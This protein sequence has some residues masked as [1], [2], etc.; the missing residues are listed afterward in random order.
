MVDWG[1][2]WWWFLGTFLDAV[3]AAPAA[4]AVGKAWD[5]VDGPIGRVD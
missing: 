1:L 4:A 3:G 5:V 2:D